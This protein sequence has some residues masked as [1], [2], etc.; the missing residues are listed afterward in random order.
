[1]L[2]PLAY[3]AC[4][5]TLPQTTFPFLAN[6]HRHIQAQFHGLPAN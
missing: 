6:G 1:M 4:K 3:R 2:T 5:R